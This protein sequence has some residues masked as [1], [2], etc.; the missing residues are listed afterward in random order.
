MA[1]EV[2]ENV[3]IG[4]YQYGFHDSTDK[5]VFTGKKGLNEQVVAQISEMKGEPAWMRDFRLNSLK[6]FNEKAMPTWGSDLSGIDFQNIHYYVHAQIVR[7][8]AGMMSRKKFAKLTI[9]WEFPKRKRN[10]SQV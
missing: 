6:I 2:K 3:D 7:K 5:Y 1:T 8:K 4:E 10:I 9:A